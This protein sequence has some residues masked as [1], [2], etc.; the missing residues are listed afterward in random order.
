MST[1]DV[2]VTKSKSSPALAAHAYKRLRSDIF[3]GRLLPGD[4]VS[5]RRLAE[6]LGMSTVPVSEALLRL[7]NEGFLESRP[8]AGTRVRVTVRVVRDAQLVERLEWVQ[9]AVAE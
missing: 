8:R 3:S 4:P 7:E 6:E 2:P 9:F 1:T 5:R